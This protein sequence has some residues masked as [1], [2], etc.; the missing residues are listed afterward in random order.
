MLKPLLSVLLFTA[1]SITANAQITVTGTV[2]DE[3]NEPVIGVSIAVK[4]TAAGNITN[5]DGHYSLSVP[6]GNAVLVFSYIGYVTQEVSVGTKTEIDI[7]LKEDIRM[8]EEVV[9]VGF[10]TQKKVNLTGAVV[11]V[12]SDVLEN[13]PVSSI[14]Q[15]LQGVVPNLNVSI[16]NGGLNT[17]PSF[18]IRGGTS[19][20]KNVSNNKWEVNNGSP[21]ILV[22]GVETGDT[23]LNM[24]NPNDIESIS[25]IKDASASAIYG[26]RASYGVMLVTTKSGKFNEKISLRYSADFQWDTPANRPDLLDARTYKYATME[27]SRMRGG[28]VS[29]WDE[30]V[31]A[32]IE[33]YRQHP[34]PENAWIY[35][36]GSQSAFT[37]VADMD[38]FK[39]AVRNWTPMQK[40]NISMSGGSEKIRYN[41]SLGFQNSDGFIKPVHDN[42]KRYNTLMSLNF[43]ATKRLDIG[44][45]INYNVSNFREP[46]LN[47]QKGTLWG[48]LLTQTAR[49]IN[50]PVKTGPNDP[51]PDAW[52]DNVVGWLMYGATNK[53]RRSTAIYSINPT[54]TLL[55]ELS[56]KGEFAYRVTD[57]DQNRI[58]PT[59][60][61]VTNNW[62][63]LEQTHTSPS[64][65]YKNK[66]RSD[67]YTVNLYADFNRTFAGPFTVSGIV[68]F[69]QESYA[70][71]QIGLTAN[72]ILSE[73]APVIDMI[74][75][76]S[77][78]TL[79]E[80]ISDWAIR[81]LFVRLN[82]NFK[83]RYF[84]EMNG[85][86]DGSSKFPKKDRFK[87]FPSVSV[88]W[89][90]SEE[91]F[92][93][94]AQK[95]LNNLKLRGNWG[96]IG[97][98]N[99]TNYAYFPTL[100]STAQVNWL[101]D[102]ARPLGI[103]PAGLISPSLTWETATTLNAGI[104]AAIFR[105]RLDFAFDLYRRRTTGILTMGRTS[106]A[107]LGTVPPLEN[108]GELTTKG[109][110]LSITW[111]D[112]PD[113][114][115]RYDVSF[116][117]SDNRSEVTRFNGNDKKLLDDAYLYEGQKPGEIWGY[118]TVG[119][120]QEEDFDRVDGKYVLKGPAQSKIASTWY[121]GDIRYRD[122]NGDGEVSPGAGTVDDP[123]DRKIIGNKTP[124]LR[125]GL[126]GNVACR[127]FDL[128]LFFQ[129]TGKRDFWISD[130]AFWG[131]GD[132][133]GNMD[134]Y[135]NSWTTG[136]TT[137]K[138]PM[139]GA[140]AQN[141]REQ[142]GYLF[143]AAYLR[144]KQ[145]VLGYTL[146]R[147]LTAGAGIDRVRFHVS[148]YN[149][150][151]ITGIP[152][153]LDPDNLS[154][155]YPVMRSVAV[156]VQIG[157]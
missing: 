124:R 103:N 153:V 147:H 91:T 97:N 21:L 24:M 30:T 44:A 76:P 63:S 58:M 40:H 12:S 60:T 54:V 140:G 85:R 127:G 75:G 106:P 25:V 43:K 69:N 90:I 37:W 36:E 118:E 27:R 13:R 23:E 121:P 145:A 67:L 56:L 134:T 49:N 83:D 50:M 89:R 111:R 143:N 146:P 84:L 72:G 131:S 18:N 71:R 65:I 55:P 3:M 32:A 7:V 42:M 116:V 100:S 80:E 141:T 115:L 78:T 39:L 57:F 114:S 122:R 123:G 26:A 6:D 87:F 16:S 74:T 79:S 38:P 17:V 53:V 117:L 68:G 82:Y 19:Y 11:S 128:N 64:Q 59:R 130:A 125:F 14:G 2:T 4:G 51:V 138:Y 99:V 10:Q 31:L 129:G 35:N 151:E 120:L 33:K 105:N 137:A 29:T 101:I 28:A 142:T 61:Y 9:V 20:A 144:L 22:D 93:E 110:D 1:I 102:G 126:T 8:I 66:N 157:F 47:T 45:R 95:W 133:A 5:P 154:S 150:L 96:S 156:G 113:G 15:A 52:T 48:A 88:A 94:P 149:L 92:M 109:W 77:L 73:S 104:D 139:Y 81:G 98:Q 70:Y 112:R 86:Y 135:K 108:A 62:A 148:G 136:H 34:V 152:K 107:V 155:V 132:S 119:I 41:L 46:W